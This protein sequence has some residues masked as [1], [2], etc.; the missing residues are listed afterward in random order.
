MLSERLRAVA[1]LVTPGQTLADIGTDHAYVPIRLVLDSLIPRAIAMD[2]NEG[3]LARAK[4]NILRMGLA[5]RIEA[6]LSDGFEALEEGEVQCAVIAG[7]GGALTI[8]I[9]SA[10]PRKVRKLDQLILQPQSEL[11]EVRKYLAENGFRITAEDM[12][13]EDGKYYPMMQVVPEE[14]GVQIVPEETGMH[15][16]PEETGMH[17]LPEKAGM[18][19]LPGKGNL[20]TVSARETGKILPEDGR[21]CREMQKEEK[22][23]RRLSFLYGPCLLAQRHPVLKQYLK[24]EE[25]I[26]GQ[27]L[28]QLAKA[29]GERSGLRREQVE[30]ELADIRLALAGFN[31]DK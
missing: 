2:V 12:V 28:M 29:G 5:D 6:R 17:I 3:P 16:V 26:R 18:K 21:N 22:L 15:T 25:R 23:P 19:T 10:F 30:E 11:Y 27:I 31:T 7:M 13:F 9:L 1:S 20:Q 14:T 4:E 8:R 24:R